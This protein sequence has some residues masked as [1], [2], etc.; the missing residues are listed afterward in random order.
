M[1]VCEHTDVFVSSSVY[2][3]TITTDGIVGIQKPLKF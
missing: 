1:I 2:L 3:F